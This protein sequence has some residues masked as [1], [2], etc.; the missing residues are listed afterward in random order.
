[1]KTPE[2]KTQGPDTAR[3]FRTALT[4]GVFYPWSIAAFVLLSFLFSFLFHRQADG[5]SGVFDWLIP[6]FADLLFPLLAALAALI[7]RN[8]FCAVLSVLCMALVLA[9]KAVN[10]ILFANVKE[11]LSYP[12]YHL[13]MEHTEHTAL[14]A[15]LGRHYPLWGSVIL[16]GAAMLIFFLCFQSLAFLRRARRSG[17]LEIT[18]VLLSLAGAG[19]GICYEL[20]QKQFS[21]NLC[22]SE[23]AVRPAE[24]Y[25]SGFV[26]AAYQDCTKEEQPVRRGFF[27]G[28][29]SPESEAWLKKEG[30]LAERKPD[31]AKRF[32]GIERIIIIAVESLD[33]AFI[34]A[35]APDKTPPG[36]TPF[37][38]KLVRTRPV[39]T[40]YFTG[41]QP[42]SFGFTS[43]VLSRFDFEEE[44]RY[45]TGSLTQS[46]AEAGFVSRYFAPTN[47]VLFNNRRLYSELFHFDAETFLEDFSREFDVTDLKEWGMADS[48]F[49]NCTAALIEQETAERS[50]SFI[51]TIDLHPEYTF[52]G[53]RKNIRTGSRFLNALACTD[54]NL[55]R[56]LTR[57][58]ANP[59][60]YNE[61]T[62]ILLTADHSATHGENYT[63]R[64]A[65]NP[66]RIP[67]IFITERPLPGL[68]TDKYCSQID[69]PATILTQLGLPVPE[70]FIGQDIFAKKSFALTW[71]PSGALTLH[72]PGLPPQI[73]PGVETL[74]AGITEKNTDPA[75]LRALTEL[76]ERYYGAGTAPGLEPESAPED[77]IPR[78]R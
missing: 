58:M 21:R 6:A 20:D 11:P 13:L 3:G 7:L 52:S 14:A 23:Y 51:S 10:L 15:Q 42:T 43:M 19:T 77:G 54:A 68:K 33:L 47:G 53:P 56:F 78:R 64:T 37:L 55:E 40:N 29:L 12:L 57:L 76:Y 41:A 61:H 75:A 26:E 32:A 35:C 31:P 50:I 46:L 9:L 72:R 34:H 30:I 45:R 27:P 24:V 8:S 22:T 70:T 60:V 36:L 1:M 62:L 49:L 66:D 59:E 4:S 2:N 38:D 44:G 39:L 67:L 74:R 5:A 28:L 48:D 69:L 16:I 65:Y 73:R 63:H 25:L 17:A 18:I 71:S